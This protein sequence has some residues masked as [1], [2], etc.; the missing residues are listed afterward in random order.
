MR[1]DSI[2]SVYNYYD[3]T[4]YIHKLNNRVFSLPTSSDSLLVHST[5]R[6]SHSCD[7]PLSA[8]NLLRKMRAFCVTNFFFGVR[9]YFQKGFALP[10]VFGRPPLPSLKTSWFVEPTQSK[11]LRSNLKLDHVTPKLYRV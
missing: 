10:I 7:T 9:A 3:I 8:N 4:L 5:H 6:I 1:Q 2:L 11:N